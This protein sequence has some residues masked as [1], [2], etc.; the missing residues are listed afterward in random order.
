MTACATG[1]APPWGDRYHSGVSVLPDEPGLL[2]LPAQEPQAPSHGPCLGCVV[3]GACFQHVRH[4]HAFCLD[5]LLCH[6]PPARPLTFVL[7][8]QK[9]RALAPEL[10]EL[11]A[12]TEQPF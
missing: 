12:E 2:G 6:G 10:V 5:G 4:A 8:F 7:R 9:G 1:E 3:I 11:V